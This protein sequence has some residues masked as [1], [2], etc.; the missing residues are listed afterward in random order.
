MERARPWRPHHA[1]V[2]VGQRLGASGIRMLQLIRCNSLLIRLLLLLRSSPVTAQFFLVV[3]SAAVMLT[4]RG[5]EQSVQH[6]G[7]GN[8][9]SIPASGVHAP[10]GREYA[11]DSR[12]LTLLHLAKRPGRPQEVAVF[13]HGV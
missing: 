2:L 13:Q 5:L 12:I 3:F 10:A 4:N 9:A 11:Y 1:Q 6:N 7:D 8:D